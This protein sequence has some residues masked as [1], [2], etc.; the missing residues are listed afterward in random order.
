[1]S[2]ANEGHVF[3]RGNKWT[4]RVTWTDASGKRRE[5]WKTGR[6]EQHARE[7]LAGMLQALRLQKPP[8][9]IPAQTLGQCS[10]RLQPGIPP[11]RSS[12]LNICMTGRSRVCGQSE[13]NACGFGFSLTT[14]E[15]CQSPAS[16]PPGSNGSRSKD[17]KRQ[18]STKRNDQSPA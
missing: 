5:Q 3:Q 10:K 2:K 7:L 6:D 8:Q 11:T 18:Q 15:M 13:R 17:S 9:P 12:P 16:R 14:S 4:A 1:M